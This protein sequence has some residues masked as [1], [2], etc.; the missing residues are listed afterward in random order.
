M[1]SGLFRHIPIK[2]VFLIDSLGAL[3]TASLLIQL[4][5]RFYEIFGIPEPT[6]Y[7]LAYIAIGF[8]LYSFICHI[9]KPKKWKI[10]LKIIALA[11]LLYCVLTMSL[12]GYHHTSITVIG[13]LYFLGEIV[14]VT[15]LSFREFELAKKQQMTQYE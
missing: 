9:L 4:L 3:I 12:I 6:L 1:S 8:S 11:N 10:Y 13:V 5:A 15:G 14:I 7:L 2:N